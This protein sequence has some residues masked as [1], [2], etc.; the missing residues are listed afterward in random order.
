[1]KRFTLTGTPDEALRKLLGRLLEEG[2]IG[3][4]F[5]LTEVSPQRY[6][7][8]LVTDPGL[9]DRIAPTLPLMPASG[10]K[11]V[12]Q[13]TMLEPV[14]DPVA[15]VLRPCELRALLEL[16]KLEQARL[17]N[18]LLISFTCGGVVPTRTVRDDFEAAVSESSRALV[19]ADVPERLRDTC[20]VCERFI[21]SGADLTLELVGRDSSKTTLVTA[22]TDRGA[23]LLDGVEPG[24]DDEPD[25]AARERLRTQRREQRDSV[26]GR[27]SPGELGIEGLVSLFGRCINCHACGSACPVCYCISCAFESADSET[28]PSGAAAELARRGATRLPSGTVLYQVGRMLHVGT[29]CVGCGMCSDACPADIPVAALFTRVAGRVQELFGYVAGRSLDEKLPTKTFE[30]DELGEIGV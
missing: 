18:L 3:G 1:M 20:R 16:V 10:G 22:G 30:T 14:P 6:S 27:F 7:Y 8:A 15:V 24:S 28:T 21:P 9:V 2:R 13:L 26:F 17:D 11:L 12:S 5:A 4:V 19:D 23:E 29:A 25:T